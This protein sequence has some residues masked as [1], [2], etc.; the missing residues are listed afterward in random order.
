MSH[1]FFYIN[2]TSRQI[3]FKKLTF[4]FLSVT[5]FTAFLESASLQGLSQLVSG[6]CVVSFLGKGYLRKIIHC[7]ILKKPPQ[8]KMRIFIATQILTIIIFHITAEKVL[9]IF[10][11][12]NW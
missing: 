7:F 5:F 6:N 1:D 9:K 3:I 10:T 4:L 8:Y 2:M 11:L 12:Y